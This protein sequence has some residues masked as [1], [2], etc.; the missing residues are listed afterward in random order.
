MIPHQQYYTAK[1]KSFLALYQGSKNINN[2]GINLKI[3]FWA[4][5]MGNQFDTLMGFMPVMLKFLEISS[6]KCD[7]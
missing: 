6:T 2:R 3:E 1:V 4:A 5:E 7:A